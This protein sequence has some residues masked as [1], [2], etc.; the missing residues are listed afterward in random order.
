MCGNTVPP[1]TPG[2]AAQSQPGQP[3]ARYRRAARHWLVLAARCT[4]PVRRAMIR[5]WALRQVPARPGSR[6]G[7]RHGGSRGDRQGR[8][9]GNGIVGGTVDIEVIAARLKA[10][11]ARIGRGAGRPAPSAN[12]QD[13]PGGP[14]GSGGSGG[15]GGQVPVGRQPS[16]RGQRS[17]GP[18]RL[19]SFDPA[20][21]ADLEYRA[22][23]G[24]YLRKWPQRSDEHTSELQ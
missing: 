6:R 20:R 15:S 1:T 24:Y 2:R 14:G 10:T 3:T 9:F 19:R 8:I 5:I 4:A 22:W 12:G 7:S 23:V 13:R 17:D 11:A 16:R 18:S 21:I